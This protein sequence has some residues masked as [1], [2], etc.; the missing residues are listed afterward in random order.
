MVGEL[1]TNQRN[2]DELDN[3]IRFACLF[4][5]QMRSLGHFNSLIWL[6]YLFCLFCLNFQFLMYHCCGIIKL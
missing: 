5:L 1:S 2:Q 6:C 4:L 3:R